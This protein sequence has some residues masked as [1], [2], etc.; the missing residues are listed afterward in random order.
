MKNR[1]KRKL[2]RNVGFKKILCAGCVMLLPVFAEA[3]SVTLSWD[4]NREGDLSGYRVH[5]GTR[6]GDYTDEVPVGNTTSYRIDGLE[7]GRRYY[8]AVT[9]VDFSGNVSGFSEEVNVD[10]P[11]S[12]PGD[13]PTDPP[14]D[15]PN[16]P[17]DDPPNDPPDDPPTDPGNPPTDPGTPANVIASVVYNFPNPF[18]VGSESTTIRYELES[19]TD[20]TIEILDMDNRVVATLVRNGFRRSGENMQDS[21]DGRNAAG[22]LVSNGV[23][24]C[25]IR[26]GNMQRFIKIAVVR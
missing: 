19:D 1:A 21:W 22:E 23:Y 3:S 13:P 24:L 26:S 25:R 18:R 16:D 15:P 8:F 2:N 4:A 6:S 20:V 9:A 14:N 10:V 17:P 12:T 7:G 5:Y 11:P